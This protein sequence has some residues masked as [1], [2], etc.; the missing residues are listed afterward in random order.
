MEAQRGR[1]SDSIILIGAVALACACGNSKNNAGDEG[2]GGTSF[3]G[4]GGMSGGGT[5]GTSGGS[6]DTGGTSGGTNGGGAAPTGGTTASGG[7]SGSTG[8]TQTGAGTGGGAGSSSAP[9]P[10]PAGFGPVETVLDG[11]SNPWRIAFHDGFLYFT[12]LGGVSDQQGNSRLARM[13]P[14]GS[15]ETLLAG[16]DIVALYLDE[17][18]LFVVER[19]TLSVF[20]M[21]YATLTPE[22]FTQTELPVADVERIG[23]RI[24]LTVF[25]G[26]EPYATGAYAL[27]RTTKQRTELLPVTTGTDFIFTYLS[28]GGGNLYL[29]TIP[30]GA[31]AN[32]GLYK[33]TGSSAGITV[34]GVWPEITSTDATHVYFAD[35][36]DGRVLRQRHDTDNQPEVLATAQYSPHSVQ[37]RPGGIYWTNAAGCDEG[38]ERVG[39]VRALP[40]G[41]GT[42][43]SVSESEI[44]PGAITTEGDYVYWTRSPNYEGVGDDSIVRARKLH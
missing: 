1:K 20:R 36:H 34:A 44:C 12:E 28:A 35:Q 2:V 31:S 22:L 7:A 37:I 40:L 3:A 13:A 9:E 11:L 21:P 14:N 41:G 10:F 24:W 32:D 17:A 23:E 26:N 15:V 27:D 4:S 39:S 16:Q 25:D 43:V 29:S 19:G 38:D 30:F 18:E 42:P 8:G 6:G 33:Y 5:G